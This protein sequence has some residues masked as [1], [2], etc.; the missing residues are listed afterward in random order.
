M[1]AGEGG[2]VGG[3]SVLAAGVKQDE[4]KLFKRV[5][6]SCVEVA[7]VL[8]RCRSKGILSCFGESFRNTDQ[9]SLGSDSFE[10]RSSK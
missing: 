5:A 4:K 7:V 3:E 6:F 10:V 2:V 9:K 8:F 1:E